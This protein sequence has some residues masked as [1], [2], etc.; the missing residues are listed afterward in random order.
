[1]SVKNKGRGAQMSQDPEQQKVKVSGDPRVILEPEINIQKV[2][3][4]HEKLTASLELND[5]IEIDAEEVKSIDTATLQ[6]FV[7]FKQEAVKLHKQVEFIASER[8]IESAKLLGVAEM[9]EV[10]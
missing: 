2:A 1:M 3:D 6:L 7:V 5:H 9:L 4:L 10:V 8:F